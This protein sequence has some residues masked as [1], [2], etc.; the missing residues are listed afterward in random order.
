MPI[1]AKDISEKVYLNIHQIQI[2]EYCALHS[3]FHESLLAFWIKHGFLTEKQES[4]VDKCQWCKD[5]SAY[6]D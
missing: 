3:D 6:Y 4:Y 5:N 2:L 1:V